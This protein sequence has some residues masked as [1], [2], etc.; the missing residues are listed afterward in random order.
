M[1]QTDAEYRTA[2]LADITL[3]MKSLLDSMSYAAPERRPEL[4]GRLDALRQ[5]MRIA[6]RLT[7]APECAIMDLSNEKRDDPGMP[8]G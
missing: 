7:A 5:K 6:E 1:T 4:R 8:T 2:L 3:Q